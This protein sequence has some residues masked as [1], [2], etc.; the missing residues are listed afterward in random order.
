MF[1]LKMLPDAVAM[2]CQMQTAAIARLRSHV[3][4]AM[5]L[6]KLTACVLLRLLN[7]V[8]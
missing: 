7:C 1:F 4:I 2:Y 5:Q 6:C 3:G 8:T